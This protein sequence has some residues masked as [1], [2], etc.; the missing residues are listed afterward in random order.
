MV[1]G[2]GEINVL[3]KIRWLYEEKVREGMWFR[4]LKV[5]IIWGNIIDWESKVVK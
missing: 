2:E 1:I 4:F 3:G 5:R